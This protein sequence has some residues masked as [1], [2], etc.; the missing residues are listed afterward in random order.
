MQ[1]YAIVHSFQSY[2][3]TKELTGIYVVCAVFKP[4]RVNCY[5]MSSFGLCMR[6]DV[7]YL[8]IF[9]PLLLG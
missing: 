6:W 2:K 9:I 8:F 1:L 5:C 3:A 4:S 7:I